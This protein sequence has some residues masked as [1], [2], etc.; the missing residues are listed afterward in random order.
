MFIEFNT[1]QKHSADLKHSTNTYS[2]STLFTFGYPNL[3]L[4]LLQYISFYLLLLYNSYIRWLS[5][6]DIWIRCAAYFIH[7]Q[8]QVARV[9]NA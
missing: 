3:M 5:N 1:F 4:S 7:T 8:A 2:H 6:C 9:Y